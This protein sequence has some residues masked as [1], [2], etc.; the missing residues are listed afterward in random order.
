MNICLSRQGPTWMPT[1]T[2]LCCQSGTAYEALFF[3]FRATLYLPCRSKPA[4]VIPRL[5]AR[6]G[7]HL[8]RAPAV[9]ANM[10]S[11]KKVRTWPGGQMA[12][13]GARAKKDC[14]GWHTGCSTLS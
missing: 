14:T 10:F 12:S 2:A 11:K 5:F 4:Q 1:I 8:R 6:P 7:M 9:A 3:N 13:T